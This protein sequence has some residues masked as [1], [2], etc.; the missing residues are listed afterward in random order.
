MLG[1]KNWLV[2][3]VSRNSLQLVGMG[4][5]KVET[6]TIPVTIINNMEIIDKD[7]L[8]T[9]I[10]EWLKLRPHIGAE[11]IWLLAPDVCFEHVLT[12]SEQDNHEQQTETSDPI[13]KDGL[14]R[15]ENDNV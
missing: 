5:E 7:G 9:L 11:I 14:R 6:I 15:D 8:Y 12:S 10:T 2:I 4:E 13:W 3:M 1:Q